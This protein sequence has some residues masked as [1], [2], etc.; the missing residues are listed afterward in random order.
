MPVKFY[1]GTH[2]PHWLARTTMSLMVS[3][4]RL[5]KVRTLPRAIC[6]WTLDSGGFSVLQKYGE[7]VIP[8]GE[9]A[10]AVIRY[11]DE[12][13]SL[14][15]AAIQDWM[16]EAFMLAKTGLTI[17]DHQ[18]RTVNSYHDLTALA[19]NVPWFPVLQ[20]Y[21]PDDYKRHIDQ[22]LASGVELHRLPRV[23][24]GSVCRRQHSAEIAQLL[25]DLYRQGL[26]LHGF[27]VK[28][29][30]LALAKN[31]LVSADSMSWSFT[32]R[33]E[34]PLP[35]HEVR[36]KNCANCQQYAELWYRTKVWPLV[37]EGVAGESKRRVEDLE[38]L[39]RQSLSKTGDRV[40]HEKVHQALREPMPPIRQLKGKIP[41]YQLKAALESAHAATGGASE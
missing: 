35:G 15:G 28:L 10:S 31:Y 16:C 32:A 12:I 26:N 25:A 22:Y 39:L 17:R 40:W 36:H 18:T 30:G 6:C 11:N 7:W 29:K 1:V 34:D 9:Y 38:A 5:R 37:Y 4:L 14:Q 20:G 41:R 21:S 3:H 19:P 8:A 33:R 27:G 2:H 23:G 13:G 24:V